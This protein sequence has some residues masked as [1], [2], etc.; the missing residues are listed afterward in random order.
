V[1]SRARTNVQ[2]PCA[3]RAGRP[4]LKRDPLGSAA[5]IDCMHS[6]YARLTTVQS[7]LRIPE[8]VSAPALRTR[9]LWH[10]C[11]ECCTAGDLTGS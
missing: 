10:A 1:R 3:L 9:T 11:A 8:G 7:P 6:T 2:L 5:R 4:Q